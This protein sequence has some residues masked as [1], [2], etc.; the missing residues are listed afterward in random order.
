[1]DAEANGQGGVA[2]V[3][4]IYVAKHDSG[5]NDDEGAIAHALG[6][7]GHEVI[8]I[9]ESATNPTRAIEFVGGGD[10]ILFHKWDNSYRPDALKH[11]PRVFWYFDLVQWYDKTLERR[12]RNRVNWMNETIRNVDIGFCTDG[13]WV[14]QDTTGKLVWL[15]QG[16]DERVVG[17]GGEADGGN[18][19]SGAVKD[20]MLR[21]AVPGEGVGRILFTGISKGGGASRE[22]FVQEMGKTYG[23]RFTHVTRGLHGRDLARAIQ[24]HDVYVCPDSPATDRYWSNR[25]YNAAGFGACILHPWCGET[26]HAQYRDDVEV[27]Y[28]QNRLHLHA[29]IE[30]Y[31]HAPRERVHL[32][33]AALERTKEQHLYRHRCAELL[34]VVKERLGVG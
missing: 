13:D 27:R 1:L 7:L 6:K 2:A 21:K 28:Y 4:I 32:R 5:G 12:C 31:L 19:G 24:E 25:I 23:K 22:S 30:H 34:D 11:L 26:L 3:R 33:Q 18:H 9:P 29:L 20:S 10:L 15:P 8:R 16:A 17:L 14:R